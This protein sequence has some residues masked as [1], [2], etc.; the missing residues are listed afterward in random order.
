MKTK[1]K[2]NIWLLLV[3]TAMFTSCNEEFLTENPTTFVDPNSL[4]VDKKGA[5]TYLIGAYDAAG[6]I[7]SSGAGGKDGWAIHWGTMG[8][9]E[10]TL[11]PWGG[12]RK[13]IFLHQVTP[14]TNTIRNI[15]ENLYVALNRV[16]STVD[17][18]GAM[19][20][21]QINS[22]DRNRMVAEAKFLRSTINFALVSAWENVP[23]ITNETTS[24]NDLE[25]SQATPEEVY[26]NPEVLESKS[27]PCI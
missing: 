8:A 10:V 27:I 25:V 2:Y 1:S 7:V 21:D 12:D 24:L 11:P 4:L 3:I 18:I 22:D 14:T 15:W 13:L 20:N 17:R 19:T 6:N 23:L 9:D 16:N 26:N 5:E